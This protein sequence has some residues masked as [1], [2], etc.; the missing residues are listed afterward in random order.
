MKILV[1]FRFIEILSLK[2]FLKKNFSAHNNFGDKMSQHICFQC[3]KVTPKEE[4]TIST[5]NEKRC[6]D[7][8][9]D[10]NEVIYESQ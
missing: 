5:D 2:E 7:C 3:K 10:N 4:I 6:I 9:L 1:A 8:V